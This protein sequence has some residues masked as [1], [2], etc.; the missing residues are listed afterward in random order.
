MSKLQDEI[1]AL[2]RQAAEQAARLDSLMADREV[3]E[4]LL[5]L[6]RETAKRLH[7]KYNGDQE[8]LLLLERTITEQA[9]ELEIAKRTVCNLNSECLSLETTNAE[10]AV[11]IAR[12][13]L[14]LSNVE[15]KVQRR[16]ASRRE[17]S[18]RELWGKIE[19]LEAELAQAMR[20]RN[21]FAIENAR[22]M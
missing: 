22:Q 8:F 4:R 15:P 16:E 12:L 2:E 18:R 20:P 5:E 13:A 19:R 6:M 9:A 10:Q 17:A 7:L 21:D 14:R 11:E 3:D 1:A